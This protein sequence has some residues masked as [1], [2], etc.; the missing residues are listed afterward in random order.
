VRVAWLGASSA[1]ERI[2]LTDQLVARATQAQSLAQS[3][4]DLGLGSIVE[5]SQAQLNATQARLSQASASYEY[6]AALAFLRY[7]SG[8]TP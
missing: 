6:A 3:R 7:L 4:Y 8:Q 5:L 2:G 1:F